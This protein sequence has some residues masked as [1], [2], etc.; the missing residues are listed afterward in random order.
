MKIG[1]LPRYGLL[2]SLVLSLGGLS[3]LA[4]CSGCATLGEPIPRLTIQ[5][6]DSNRFWVDDR[7]VERQ[8][9]PRAVRRAGAGA[10]TEILIQ[11]APGQT[12]GALASAY[13][14]LQNAGHHKLF[15]T[16]RR[17]ATATIIDTPPAAPPPPARRLPAKRK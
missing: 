7:E 2:A 15:F 17:E 16:T 1:K 8:N 10:E 4:V 5:A 14:V 9:L 12:P 13:A 11:M 6:L 3:L